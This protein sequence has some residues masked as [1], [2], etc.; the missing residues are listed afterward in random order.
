MAY[1]TNLAIIEDHPVMRQSL[2]D[3]FTDTGRWH[4]T[5]TASTHA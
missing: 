1:K 5:G 3:W 2:A 4:V